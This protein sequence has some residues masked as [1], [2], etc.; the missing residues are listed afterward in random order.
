MVEYCYLDPTEDKTQPTLLIN[1][2]FLLTIALNCLYWFW[3]YCVGLPIGD[4]L[5]LQRDFHFTYQYLFLALHSFELLV[6]V[7]VL[8]CCFGI[9]VLDCL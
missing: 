9:V 6:L 8:L 4:N 3:Y 2:F 5:T 1:T 7:S